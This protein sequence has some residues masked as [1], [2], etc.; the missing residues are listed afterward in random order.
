[1]NEESLALFRALGDDEGIAVLLHRIAISTL[2]HLRDPARAREL[3]AESREHYGRVGSGRGE[4]EVVGALGY[5]ARDEG[6]KEAA[7]ELFTRAAELA[8]ETGFTWWEVGMLG[9]RV[10]CLL[11]LGRIDDAEPAA[12][13]HLELARAIGERQHSVLGLVLHAWIAA[14]RGDAERA[15]LLWG[16]VEAEERW[17][18]L[19]QWEAERDEYAAKVGV[20]SGAELDRARSRGRGLSLQAAIEEALRPVGAGAP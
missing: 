18:L 5:V 19:G 16:A 2:I 15:H 9:A 12:R 1:M 10:E 11:E 4:S 3:L 17:G 13:R 8:D 6:D 20:R 7:L 14:R